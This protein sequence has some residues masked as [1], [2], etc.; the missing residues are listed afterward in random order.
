LVLLIGP[1][2][3]YEAAGLVVVGA[4]R[5][6]TLRSR[7]PLKLSRLMFWEN[8]PRGVLDFTDSANL[9]TP[10]RVHR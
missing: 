3:G 4:V 2:R 7:V 1:K 10:S 6:I 9:V 8:P 5:K